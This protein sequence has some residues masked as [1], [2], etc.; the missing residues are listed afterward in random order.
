VAATVKCRRI[1]SVSKAVGECMKY[2]P[3]IYVCKCVGE[4]GSY[5]QMPTDSFCR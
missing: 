3:N 5:C 4:C 2:R 1:H